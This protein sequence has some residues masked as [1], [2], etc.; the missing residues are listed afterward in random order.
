MMISEAYVRVNPDFLQ[1]FSLLKLRIKLIGIY[2]I[3]II[4]NVSP[5]GEKFVE[6]FR[7]VSCFS[8]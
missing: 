4:K 6:F 5:E 8:S 1:K 7:L 3:K 2:I